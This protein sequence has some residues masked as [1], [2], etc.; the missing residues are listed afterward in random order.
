MV[1]V[2]GPLTMDIVWECPLYGLPDPKL[3]GIQ[4]CLN[5]VWKEQHS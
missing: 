4:L 1:G 5:N 2:L 3:C